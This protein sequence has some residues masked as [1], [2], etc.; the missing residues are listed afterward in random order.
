MAVSFAT[1]TFSVKKSH[2][3]RFFLWLDKKRYL[4]FGVL[5]KRSAGTRGGW[6]HVRHRTNGTAQ[7]YSVPA[8]YDGA[9]VLCGGYDLFSL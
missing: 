1:K 8:A 2:A 3:F 5:K 7:R 6:L 9:S 4:L